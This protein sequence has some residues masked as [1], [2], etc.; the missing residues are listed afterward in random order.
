[1][2]HVTFAEVQPKARNACLVK[3]FFAAS[4]QGRSHSFPLRGLAPIRGCRHRP[5][6][7][8]EPNRKAF[9]VQALADELTDVE[10]T[11]LAHLGRPGTAPGRIVGPDAYSRRAAIDLPRLLRQRLSHL[12][13]PPLP[14]IGAPAK[15]R[16][17]LAF[18]PSRP[19]F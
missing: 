10:L 13:A 14:R 8:R 15:P 16:A 2:P 4:S 1:R 18:R 19:P 12:F 5:G 11:A 9:H 3:Q 6:I 17:L 7:S